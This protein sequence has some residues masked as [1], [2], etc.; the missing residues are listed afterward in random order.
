MTFAHPASWDE[1]FSPDKQFTKSRL[2]WTLV[3]AVF[4]GIAGSFIVA[5]KLAA[6]HHDIVLAIPF[7]AL[8]CA[9]IYQATALRGFVSAARRLLQQQGANEDVRIA[10]RSYIALFLFSMSAIGLFTL[11]FLL[12]MARH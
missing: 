4:V 7:I 10:V 9:A 3:P 6:N 11:A 1:A 12:F 2:F 8:G 5:Y